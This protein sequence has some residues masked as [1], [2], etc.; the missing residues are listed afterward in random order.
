MSEMIARIHLV[1]ESGYIKRT[2]TKATLTRVLDLELQS[3]GVGQHR[4][5][6]ALE[7]ISHQIKDVFV[8]SSMVLKLCDAK[9]DGISKEIDLQQGP[10]GEFVLSHVSSRRI[11]VSGMKM[12]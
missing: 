10:F 5:F 8:E 3:N 1:P 4:R 12:S 9:W 7:K 11:N 2:A 6:T